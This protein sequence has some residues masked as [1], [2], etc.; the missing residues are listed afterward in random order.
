MA[1][2]VLSVVLALLTLNL[3]ANAGLFQSPISPPPPNDD[4]DSATVISGLPFDEWLDTEG[5]T[6]ADDDPEDCSSAGS[7]WYEFTPSMDMQIEAMTLGSGYD[8]IL[9]AYTAPRGELALVACNDNWA[10]G[11]TSRVYFAVT[12][13][14]TYYFLVGW[15]AGWSGGYLSFAL[16]E[17]SL[18]SND[19]FVVAMP[20]PGLDFLDVVEIHYAT[21][22]AGEPL[23]SCCQ[24]DDPVGG[25][26]W[27]SFTPD[28]STSIAA[29]WWGSS[30]AVYTGDALDELSEIGSR[31]WNSPLP[32]RAEAG[33]TYYFQ[34]RDLAD[35]ANLGF[36]LE[37]T[38]PPEAQF[39]FYPGDPS[40]F[41]DVQFYDYSWD[42]AGVGIE[43]QAWDLGD[44]TSATGCCPTHRYASDGTYTVQ[45]TV[46]TYDNRQASTSQT[47]SVRTHDVAIA[48]FSAPQAAKA[49]QTRPIVV[50]IR[51]K[52]YPEQVQVE[53]YKSFPGG[54]DHIGGLRQYVPIRS[55]GR[56]TDFKFSY[57]FTPEDASIGKVTF[58]AVAHIVDSRDALP[59]DNEA[60]APPTKVSR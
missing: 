57:T 21:G 48:R 5:A 27:Y 55:G 54:F 52:A 1:S 30:V 23:P 9:S 7:V 6:W 12:A 59:A 44:G 16:Q 41:E 53:L 8:T 31:C 43:S 40:V 47:V 24:P 37:F 11:Q 25:T 22:E 26:V 33:T 51:N 4:F 17:V 14:T 3:N 28:E 50:G 18:P 35:Y 20:I 15:H 60:I 19:N 34:A 36:R 29:Y 38:P 32:F 13:D 2:T 42:P 46:A 39:G 10:Y 45:L 58:M 49:G 56:T